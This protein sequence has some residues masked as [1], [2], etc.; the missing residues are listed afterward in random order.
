MVVLLAYLHLRLTNS[1]VQ[2]MHIS[3]VNVLE[4]VI[5]ME[6][7]TIAI[8]YDIMH[9]Q[10]FH[11]HIYIWS[12]D[13]LTVVVKGMDNLTGNSLQMVTDERHYNCRQIRSNV[14]C[15]DYGALNVDLEHDL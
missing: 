6:H 8:K 5:D 10:A 15:M 4:M 1:K 2:V 7:I 14:S 12:Y 13:F 11:W 9:L 3:L